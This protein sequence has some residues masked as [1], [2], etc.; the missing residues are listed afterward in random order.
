[1]THTK[2]KEDSVLLRKAGFS[3]SF[4]SKKIGIS[5]STLSDWLSEIPYSP[6]KETI[7]KIK[8][9]QMASAQAKREGKQRSI[10]EAY[11]RAKKD[12][13]KLSNRD[14]F[15]LGLGLYIGEGSKTT[16]QIRIVSSNPRII[17]LGMK[18]LQS[19]CDL[20]RK[21]FTLRLHLY[22]DNN[23]NQ[24]LQYWSKCTGIPLKNFHKTNI[25]KRLNKKIERKGTLPYGTAHLTVKSLGKKEFGVYLFRRLMSW[26]DIVLR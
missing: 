15:M 24:C 8:K 3:Y 12:I 5:K 25:D 4:I 22:P 9:A 7:Q 18:W 21:N 20:K 10:K 14:L 6:N 19:C 26:M 13:G 1:M 16:H 11:V 17:Q 23:V 2:L